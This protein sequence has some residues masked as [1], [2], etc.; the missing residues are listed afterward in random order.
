[1]RWKVQITLPAMAL[2]NHK[3]VGVNT[4]LRYT[5]TA[6]KVEED[7]FEIIKNWRFKAIVDSANE[8]GA[9]KY[10]LAICGGLLLHFAEEQL[11][12]DMEGE[13]KTQELTGFYD[14]HRKV[15]RPVKAIEVDPDCFQACV[16]S[17]LIVAQDEEESD[18]ES[19]PD[20]DGC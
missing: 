2:V 17:G 10:A 12:S 7:G 8:V 13:G 19:I 5:F 9:V 1:M 16:D 15:I 3:R 18:D 6:D 4:P 14:D 20:S 11:V